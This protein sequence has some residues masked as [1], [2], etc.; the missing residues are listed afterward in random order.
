[1]LYHYENRGI[2]IQNKTE[3]ARLIMR[4]IFQQTD[5]LLPQES[6]DM[7]TWA[8]IACDQFT[9]DLAF[10]ARVRVCVGEKPSTLHMILPEAWLGQ[11]D[12]A[13]YSKQINETMAQYLNAGVFREVPASF[14]YVERK[15]RNGKLRRGIVGAVDLEQYATG[16]GAASTLRESERII[17]SRLPARRQIRQ[18]A[19][20]EMPH[21]LVLIDDPNC[22]IVEP[23][24][25]RSDLERLYDFPLMEDCGHLTGYRVTGELAEQVAEAI[26]ALPIILVGD[27]NHSLVAAK[28]E[29][30]AIK[31]TLSEVERES[32]PARYALVELG[33]VYDESLEIEPIHRI[34]FD[35]EGDLIAEFA[36]SSPHV[37]LGEGEGY[38]I[39]FLDKGKPGTV[40]ISGLTVGETIDLLQEF[41][42]AYVQTHG[43][44]IDYIHG[45]A[46]L[47]EFA[48]KE[49]SIAFFMPTIAKSALFTSVLQG[50]VFPKKSFSMGDGADKRHYVECRKIK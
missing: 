15:L 45:D 17:A 23:L 11:V 30:D 14:V 49:G 28:M 44:E 26:H 36:A 1:M 8:V 27:G 41:L 33:N 19:L 18:E 38:Q 4:R 22:S 37:T 29:W 9:S 7:E 2:L 21:V 48:Q 42:D 34:V 20:L 50:G 25:Q 12:E 39:R 35:T 6:V 3:E 43:G 47:T 32:H 40:T 5:I 16:T 46:E 24:G 10:W 31:E 13:V